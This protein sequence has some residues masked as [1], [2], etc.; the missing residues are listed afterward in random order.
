MSDGPLSELTLLSFE[1]RRAAEIAQLVAGYGGEIISAPS[2]REVPLAENDAVRDLLERLDAGTIDVL[3]LLTGVG[4]T[5][6]VE[7]LAPRC[8]AARLR[9][10]LQRPRIIARG[11]KPRAALR[12]TLGME[13]DFNV[14][15]PNTWREL[16]TTVET[17]C[18]PLADK[19]IAVQEYGRT[20]DE[21]LAALRSRGA[22]VLSVPVYRWGLPEDLEPLRRGVRTLATGAADVALFT[23]AQQCA[24][25]LQ[26]AADLGLDGELRSTAARVAFASVGPICSEALRA[27]GLPVDIEPA[28][29]KMGPLIREVAQQARHVLAAKRS[30]GSLR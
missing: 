22:E 16:V 1:S 12:T 9:E 20:N 19:A 5:A 15:E 3:V 18:S 29:P 17:A 25:V 26:V 21:L 27:A 13:P 28:K 14:P 4:T 8:S 2:M 23:S 10:L 30:N 7:V 11:P 6:L 24:H